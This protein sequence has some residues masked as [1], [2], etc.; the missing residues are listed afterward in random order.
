MFGIVGGL[1]LASLDSVPQDL[2]DNAAVLGTLSLLTALVFIADLLMSSHQGK[3]HD[4]TQTFGSKETGKF[5]KLENK[6]IA[7][8][9]CEFFFA[10][11]R[12]EFIQNFVKISKFSNFFNISFK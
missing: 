5:Q 3:K 1:C 11:S 4:A 2:I 7:Q 8:K 9:Q 10:S 6:I 12:K